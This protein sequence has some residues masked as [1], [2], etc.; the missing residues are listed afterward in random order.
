MNDSSVM[1]IKVS[2]YHSGS[3]KVLL[4]DHLYV[5]LDFSVE[6]NENLRII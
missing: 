3:S 1:D 6:F 4:T 2:N 5:M